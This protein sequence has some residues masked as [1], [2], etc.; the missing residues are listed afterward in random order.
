MSK[1]RSVGRPI[2]SVR[3]ALALKVVP[4]R[5]PGS[6]MKRCF[7]NSKVSAFALS[8]AVISVSS[9]AFARLRTISANS[10]R[11]R[12]VTTSGR[13]SL[14]SCSYGVISIFPGVVPATSFWARETA[15]T[16]TSQSRASAS[17]L[18]GGRK[19]IC[20]SCS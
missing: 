17:A 16:S 15:T 4:S 7:A 20:T 10:P 5:R 18:R 14:S 2:Q 19:L 9:G 3:F 13:S 8:T 11:R 1:R 6:A 12:P